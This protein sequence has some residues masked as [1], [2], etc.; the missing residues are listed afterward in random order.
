MPYVLVP[1]AKL[2]N[3]SRSIRQLPWIAAL[4]LSLGGGAVYAKFD[5]SFVWTTLETPHFL[6][7]YHQDGEEI[8][9]RA[10]VIA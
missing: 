2:M 7:H 10:A 3:L 1:H 8:A 4:L 5:P 6:I 9:K